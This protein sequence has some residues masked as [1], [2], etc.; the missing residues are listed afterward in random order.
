VGDEVVGVGDAV[1]SPGD[2]GVWV[3]G[4]GE[5]VRAFGLGGCGGGVDEE[6]RII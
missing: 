3:G 1:V 5:D 4:A 2:E 6:P